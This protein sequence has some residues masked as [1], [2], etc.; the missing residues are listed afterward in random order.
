MYDP[1][2]DVSYHRPS[3]ALDGS[4][5]HEGTGSGDDSQHSDDNELHYLIRCEYNLMMMMFCRS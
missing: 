1:R 3:R 5:R 2:S 4:A